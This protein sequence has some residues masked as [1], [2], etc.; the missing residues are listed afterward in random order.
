MRKRF[1]TRAR[2]AIFCA[3][4][5]RLV[6]G[7]AC[8]QKKLDLDPPDE[9]RRHQGR[10]GARLPTDIVAATTRAPIQPPTT[11]LQG[12]LSFASP[13][14][15][16]VRSCTLGQGSHTPPRPHGRCAA[17]WRLA[18]SYASTGFEHADSQGLA[19]TGTP[20]LSSCR[21]SSE[22]ARNSSATIRSLHYLLERTMRRASG[23][24]WR[25]P[26]RLLRSH[27]HPD[28]RRMSSWWSRPTAT[29]S[30]TPSTRRC[31]CAIRGSALTSQAAGTSAST[32][33][34]SRHG[35]VGA[36]PRPRPRH[37]A[38]VL[39]AADGRRR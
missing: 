18:S 2:V 38:A 29:C 8:E 15:A 16:G 13:P 9:R 1:A 14:L 26:H 3:S 7:Y 22:T 39:R 36:R 17:V 6:P 27:R 20:A 28:R 23:S 10:R 33:I 5:L 21:S 35:P 4:G 11:T 25:R 31:R 24:T 37:G 30:R 19:M 32:A 12:P 34:A